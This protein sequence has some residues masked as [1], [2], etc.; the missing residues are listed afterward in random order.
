PR[1]RRTRARGTFAHR[2]A[3]PGPITQM[4]IAHRRPH[5]LGGGGHHAATLPPI[6]DGHRVVLPQASARWPLAI[7]QAA[8]NG[9]KRPASEPKRFVSEAVLTMR[10]FNN[11][12]ILYMWSLVPYRVGC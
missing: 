1:R 12:K 10:N 8:R 4:A 6:N 2:V 3:D 5:R 9:I 11:F 7:N